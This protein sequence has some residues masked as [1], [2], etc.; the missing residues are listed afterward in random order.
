MRGEDGK[1]RG[2][3]EKER[4]TREFRTTH[5]VGIGMAQVLG[6]G[7]AAD[8]GVAVSA[9]VVGAGDLGQVRGLVQAGGRLVLRVAGARQPSQGAKVQRAVHHVRAR[10]QR[11]LFGPPVHGY[12]YICLAHTLAFGCFA[13]RKWK[14]RRQRR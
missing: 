7:E 14:G 5:R 10:R 2:Q 12:Q 11:V 4:R 13:A 3:E 8:A 1:K 6:G 9:E